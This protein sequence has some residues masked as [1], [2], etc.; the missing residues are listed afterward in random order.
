[1]AF[2]KMGWKKDP[3]STKDKPYTGRLKAER[4]VELPAE[5]SLRGGLPPVFD[6]GSEGSCVWNATVAAEMYG[7]WK[8]GA[9]FTMLSRQFGYYNTRL[10]EGT[11]DEDEGCCIRNAMKV[12][13][14]LG[15]PLETGSD[16]WPYSP[17]NVFKC[18][19]LR[20][21]MAA[22]DHQLLEFFRVDWTNLYEVQ[23]C[24]AGVDGKGGFPIVWG[25]TLTASF[26]AVG[27]NGV[28][29]V[30]TAG[31]T[32]LG[33]HA[34]LLCGYKMIGGKLHFEDRNSW[35]DSW[36]DHGYGW[37]PAEIVTS[38]TLSDDFWTI[39]KVEA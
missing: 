17:N 35:G 30:P 29:A 10:A 7:Q 23:R 22:R 21:Y 27:A 13:S 11:K 26:N 38:P 18:P 28:V 39:R 16:G 1:M 33:G 31:E 34:K 12:G 24:L 2:H 8:Q 25:Q 6:Q 37:V 14:H 4:Q 36:G 9:S 32:Q 3:P 19:P 5:V 20:C 15:L